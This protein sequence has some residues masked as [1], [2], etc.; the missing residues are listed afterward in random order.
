MLKL[1]LQYFGH[2]MCRTDSLEKTLML[3]KIEDRRTRGRQRMRWLMAS[4][5]RWTWVWVSSRSWWWT[6]KPGVLQSMVLQR[7]G[8]DWATELNW[9]RLDAMIFIFL[10]LNFKLTDGF[11]F[12][13][14]TQDC[15][16]SFFL[17][18]LYTEYIMWNARLDK[19]QAGIKIAGRNIY[20]FRYASDSTLRTES[21]EE[22]KILLMRVKEEHENLGQLS[23]SLYNIQRDLPLLPAP[24]FLLP[25]PPASDCRIISNFCSKAPFC[26]PF[27]FS[28]TG[29]GAR[30]P[31]VL[32][33]VLPTVLS[34]FQILPQVV[35]PWWHPSG[36]PAYS[37]CIC[38]H[39][40]SYSQSGYWCFFRIGSWQ[41]NCSVK[42]FESHSPLGRWHCFSSTQQAARRLVSLCPGWYPPLPSV[43][44]AAR[45]RVQ[46]SVLLF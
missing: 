22:L 27:S 21:E 29:M 19:S 3:G 42:A 5:T 11:K 44:N 9:V 10:M 20:S 37:E 24:H 41:A 2:L 34:V 25:V 33:S 40:V 38:M 39:L 15:I 8:H 36:L 4:L 1:K 7:V 31:W 32:C 35:I 18:N 13:K 43:P 16:L 14:E 46:T 6:G 23:W 30:H 12:G 28:W 45:V 26:M 17:F